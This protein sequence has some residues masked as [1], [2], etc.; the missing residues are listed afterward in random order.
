MRRVDSND[1]ERRL[2]ANPELVKLATPILNGF[3]KLLGSLQHVVYVTDRDGIVLHSTGNHALMLAYGLLPGYD[4]SEAVM[5]TNGAGTALATNQAVAVIGPEHYQ[6][7]FHNTSCF[8]APIHSA[9]GE[10]IG[11]IDLSTALENATA[12]H[13]AYVTR[14]ADYIERRLNGSVVVLV[15]DD[16][17]TQ[18]YAVRRMLME[19]R[20]SVLV[21]GTGAEA[22]ELAK[23]LPDAI[24]LDVKLPD[25][26]GFEVCRRLKADAETADIPVIHLSA[27]YTHAD[28]QLDGIYAGAEAYLI[29]PVETVE[30]VGI[31]DKTFGA[32]ARR[33]TSST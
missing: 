33:A 1:L 22:L 32:K 5:G 23:R 21:A 13:L 17:Q 19:E 4:W 16:D 26:N 2:A 24:V 10:I 25:I 6:Q 12:E 9:A 20:F 28:A 15:V 18:R 3:S 7:P 14:L 11:A 30:L 27:V 29:H 31:I 8:A